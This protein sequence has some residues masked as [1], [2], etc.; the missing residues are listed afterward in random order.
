MWGH[1][2]GDLGAS[3]DMF[4]T[5][6]GGVAI[7]V[8]TNG[9]AYGDDAAVGDGLSVLEQKLFEFGWS[10]PVPQAGPCALPRGAPAAGATPQ[11]PASDI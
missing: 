3:T 4:F 6:D 5:A 10:L 7:V 2:G 9:E 11:P 1:N 8:L